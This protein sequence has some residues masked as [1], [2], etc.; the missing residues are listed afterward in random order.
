MRCGGKLAQTNGIA[1]QANANAASERLLLLGPWPNMELSV[2]DAGC[3]GPGL[4]GALASC[5]TGCCTVLDGAASTL[6]PPGGWR[7]GCGKRKMMDGACLGGHDDDGW[8]VG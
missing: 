2:D 5:C 1:A 4:G 8:L 6:P 3:F 7:P